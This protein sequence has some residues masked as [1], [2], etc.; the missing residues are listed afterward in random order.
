MKAAFAD[1]SEVLAGDTLA[2]MVQDSTD[3]FD[4]ESAS[5]LDKLC[6]DWGPDAAF[7]NLQKGSNKENFGNV[8]S[9]ATSRTGDHVEVI[10][11]ADKKYYTGKVT[12]IHDGNDK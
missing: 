1:I 4:L 2:I 10:K 3:P 12:M 8:I 6:T 5:V 9:P 11:R 7:S